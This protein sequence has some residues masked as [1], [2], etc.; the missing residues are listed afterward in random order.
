MTYDHYLN[1]QKSILEWK[2]NAL[3]ARNPELEKNS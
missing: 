1:Q 3:L 2:L